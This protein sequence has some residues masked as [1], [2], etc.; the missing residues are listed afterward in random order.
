MEENLYIIGIEREGLRC[1]KNGMLSKK[2][3]PKAFDD[4]MK[5]NFITTDWGEAQIELRTPAC[6]STIE[7]EEKLNEITNV[8]LCELN[9]QDELLWP[10]SMQ[11]ILPREEEFPW[12]DYGDFIEEH[13]YEMYLYRKYGYKMHC[14]S[15]IHVNVSF[16]KILFERIK[17]NFKNIPDN[18]DDAY[19]KI[20][21]VFLKKAWMLMYFFGATP[22]QLEDKETSKRR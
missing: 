21:R 14:M 12:G 19:L 22:L 18:L 4:R 13:E 9:N 11:C 6:K 1:D 5:N 20:M 3:H 7:C 2:K 10:Y 17:K 16:N 15:G 8:V